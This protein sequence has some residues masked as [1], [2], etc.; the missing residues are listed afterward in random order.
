MLAVEPVAFRVRSDAEIE[1]TIAS[2]GREQAGLVVMDNSF[3]AAHHGALIAAA[4]RDG[5]PAIF[6]FNAGMTREGAL[7]AYG[8]R[9]YGH[10]PARGWLRG[11]HPARNHAVRLTGP[12]PIE[13]DLAI[14]AKTAKSLGITVPPSLLVAADE[15]VE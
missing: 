6:G 2:L 8:P 3:M 15:V 1:T 5:V 11:S 13:Y 7:M 14:N 4:A 9:Y 10:V 12:A